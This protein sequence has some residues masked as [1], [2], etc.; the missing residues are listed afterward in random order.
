MCFQNMFDSV[1]S[2]MN[3][4]TD[5]D[6][7]MVLSRVRQIEVLTTKAPPENEFFT[8]SGMLYYQSEPPD[9]GTGLQT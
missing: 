2:P 9:L 6:I 7:D 1:E 8:Y 4:S 3:M 5:V